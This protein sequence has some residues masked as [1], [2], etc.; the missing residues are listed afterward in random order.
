M[1]TNPNKATKEPLIP[2]EVQFLFI[3]LTKRISILTSLFL[4]VKIVHHLFFLGILKYVSFHIQVEA[5][6]VKEK[7]ILN[8]TKIIFCTTEKLENSVIM[9]NLILSLRD[10]WMVP[11]RYFYKKY[12]FA[13]RV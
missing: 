5:K 10:L 3:E 1:I 6:K 12:Y 9:A 4:L 13:K 8:Y 11:S 2:S 7:R